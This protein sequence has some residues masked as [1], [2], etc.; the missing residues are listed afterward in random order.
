MRSKRLLIAG[1]LGALFCAFC[2]ARAYRSV[3]LPAGSKSVTMR[4]DGRTR[5]Y[6]LHIPLNHDSAKQVPLVMVLHG[7]T[8]SPE[9]AE[10]MSR[11]SELADKNDFIAVYPS[12][13]GRDAA[14]RVPTWNAGACCAYAMQNNVDDVGFLRTLI[15]QLERDDN[16]DP[17]RVYVTGISNGAMLSYRLACELSGKIAAI[18]PV[19]GAQDVECIPTDRVSLIVFHGTADHLVPFNGGSTPFQMGSER[20]DNSVAGAISF[21]VKKD[22]CSPTP[23]HAESA[24]V[25]T[26]F[27]FGCQDGSAVALYA[28]QGGHHM[29]PGL[30][31][32][33]NHVPASE[34]MW[35]FFAA[36]PKP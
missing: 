24:E 17:K 13:T 34:I 35:Q 2:A 26:D 9:S 7:A 33:G 21:W 4:F 20:K 12:G 27:Y 1:V 15:D 18:A 19:E 3:A 16:I 10:R 14:A 22:G 5:R 11:M 31:I 6:I 30:R 23:E 36:H 28:I 29:W 32:S 8:Q 25:H